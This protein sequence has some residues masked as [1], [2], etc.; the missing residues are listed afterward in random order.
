MAA[1]PPAA[2]A[3]F[4]HMPKKKATTTPAI[5][6]PWCL[7]TFKKKLSLE[8]GSMVKMVINPAI[9]IKAMIQILPILMSFLSSA[10]R[11]EVLLVEVKGHDGGGRVHHR[12][13]TG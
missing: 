12:V 5:R 6:F 9:T 4:Q 10:S 13:E 2:V 8:F 7:A 1:T 3:R 11:I